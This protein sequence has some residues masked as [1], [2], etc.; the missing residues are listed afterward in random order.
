M[1]SVTTTDERLAAIE[2]KLDAL[3]QV[4]EGV[5]ETVHKFVDTVKPILESGIMGLLRK[6][7]GGD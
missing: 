3:V 2:G 7:N 4:V 5:R 6:R 1:E